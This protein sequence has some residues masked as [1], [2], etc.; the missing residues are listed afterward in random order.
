M[1]HDRF[2]ADGNPSAYGR[3]FTACGGGRGGAGRLWGGAGTYRLPIL[4]AAATAAG[5]GLMARRFAT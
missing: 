3:M 2:G 1:I 4:L 5:S